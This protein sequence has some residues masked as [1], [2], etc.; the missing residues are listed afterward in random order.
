MEEQPHVVEHARAHTAVGADHLDRQR[1]EL[2]RDLGRRL[3]AEGDVLVVE[4]HLGHEREVRRDG[5][6]RLDGEAELLE[7]RE[8]LGDESV[9]AALEQ[10]LG[11]LAERG[12]RLGLAQRA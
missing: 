4:R 9:H 2:A 10:P 6:D 5:A 12:G 3:P 8:G 11:L 1:G 7:I